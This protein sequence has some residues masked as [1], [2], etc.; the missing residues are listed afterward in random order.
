AAM[1]LP[2]FKYAGWTH[3]RG[4]GQYDSEPDHDRI[5]MYP[6]ARSDARLFRD[7]SSRRGARRLFRWRDHERDPGIPAIGPVLVGELPVA[8]EIEI[9]LNLTG[10]GNDE[11]ELGASANDL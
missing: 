1:R 7:H 4:R 9:P 6:H 5:A 10:Q 3:T 2:A 8:F 11:S